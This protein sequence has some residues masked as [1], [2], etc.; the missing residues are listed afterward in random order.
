MTWKPIS[1]FFPGEQSPHYTVMQPVHGE[2]DSMEA[3]KEFFKSGVDELNF[4]LFSTSGVHGTYTSI[5]EAEK[6]PGDAITYLIV[7]PRLVCLRYGN[8]T[9]ETPEDF[10]FLKKLRSD[11]WNVIKNIG[12]P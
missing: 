8:V 1:K 4:I 11:S 6:N 12:A 7:H 5:E 2:R 9:P 3:L 10:E